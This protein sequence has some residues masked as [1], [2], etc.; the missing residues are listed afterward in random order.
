MGI[1][2]RFS[3]CQTGPHSR[4]NSRDELPIAETNM[5]QSKRGQKNQDRR[6]NFA[7]KPI[8]YRIKRYDAVAVLR[9]DVLHAL[10]LSVS[11]HAG[12]PPGASLFPAEWRMPCRS[13]DTLDPLQF[14]A[15]ELREG[16]AIA[17]EVPEVLAQQPCYCQRPVMHSLLDCF[18]TLE[19]A[20]C[21]ICVD[22]AHLAA[23]L[24]QQGK[25]GPEIR[26]VIVR[27]FGVVSVRGRR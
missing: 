4:A 26:A 19:A 24:H 5:E 22:E 1:A 6:A 8:C 3:F 9:V 25:T 7:G 2:T 14:P 12:R 17:K 20:D 16:Y 23:R 21:K 11:K 27:Q 13:L 18:A 10:L 15:G